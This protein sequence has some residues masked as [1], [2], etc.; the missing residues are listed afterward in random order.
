MIPSNNTINVYLRISSI[1]AHLRMKKYCCVGTKVTDVSYW[2]TSKMMVAC[3]RLTGSRW[4]ALNEA[5]FLWLSDQL[6]YQADEG[7]S[8]CLDE[9]TTM[10]IAA[11]RKW[12]EKWS[13]HSEPSSECTFSKPLIYK[14][15]NFPGHH[16]GRQHSQVGRRP[17]VFRPTFVTLAAAEMIRIPDPH[18][19]PCRQAATSLLQFTQRFDSRTVF[20]RKN[21]EN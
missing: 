2:C 20:I 9:N 21:C 5:R 4:A 18:T 6:R 15:I 16:C 12:A 7:I 17:A 1:L 19:Y 10:N 3:W 8:R 14:W 13:W 11:F